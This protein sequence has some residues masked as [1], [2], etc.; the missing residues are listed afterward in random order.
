M[1]SDANNVTADTF[2][3]TSNT[4]RENS[5]ALFKSENLDKADELEDALKDLTIKDAKYYESK[6]VTVSD[7]QGD[8]TRNLETVTHTSN[9]N[10]KITDTINRNFEQEC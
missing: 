7:A 5:N 3:H 2:S 4:Q 1:I 6:S 10:G 9:K 8:P